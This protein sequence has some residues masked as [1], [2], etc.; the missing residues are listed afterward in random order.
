[1]YYK[2]QQ[3]A[4]WGEQAQEEFFTGCHVVCT[5][6]DTN[7][8]FNFAPRQGKD[9]D[10]KENDGV[11]RDAYGNPVDEK[12]APPTRA[13][14]IGEINNLNPSRVVSPLQRTMAKVQ[15]YQVVRYL[16]APSSKDRY[17]PGDQVEHN[18]E[19]AIVISGPHIPGEINGRAV[20]PGAALNSSSPGSSMFSL[21]GGLLPPLEAVPKAPNMTELREDLEL[22]TDDVKAPVDERS[23]GLL[24]TT[25]DD[26]PSPS[27]H[28]ETPKFQ[29]VHSFLQDSDP[30]VPT[31]V[32]SMGKAHAGAAL[33][34]RQAL[35]IGDHQVVA[36]SYHR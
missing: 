25:V 8:F 22:G 9:D 27:T 16:G 23:R 3:R 17:K 1:M 32:P 30:T 19:K 14:D 7:Q 18:G 11:E 12:E 10:M 21:P 35:G 31:G 36:R 4:Q 20:P 28:P 34:S 15:Q 5:Y 6:D 13:R 26:A 29:S 24:W 33:A 2:Q